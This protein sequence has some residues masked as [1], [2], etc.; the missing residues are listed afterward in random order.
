[1]RTS[2]E[3]GLH[4]RPS[5]SHCG[6]FRILRTVPAHGNGCLPV[7]ISRRR[8]VTV[9]GDQAVFLRLCEVATSA[10][11]VLWPTKVRWSKKFSTGRG[12]DRYLRVDGTLVETGPWPGLTSKVLVLMQSQLFVSISL[13]VTGTRATAVGL[14]DS[15]SRLVSPAR[16]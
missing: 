14:R 8:A 10:V 13:D 4:F 15:S 12:Y 9:E 16:C 1:M 2:E 5:S 6:C 11:R 3:E 7:E